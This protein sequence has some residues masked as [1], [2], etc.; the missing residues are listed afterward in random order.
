MFRLVPVARDAEQL[1]SPAHWHSSLSAERKGLDGNSTSYGESRYA[2]VIGTQ[3]LSALGGLE[4]SRDTTNII[5]TL[6]PAPRSTR[7]TSPGLVVIA[8]I[9]CS[10]SCR[11]R[12]QN[13][14][15]RWD[16]Y[17]EGQATPHLHLRKEHPNRLGGRNTQAIKYILRFLL[18]ARFHSS[19]D[20][21]FFHSSNVAHSG[22]GLR[23]MIIFS[24]RRRSP[25]PWS[26]RRK[27]IGWTAWFDRFLLGE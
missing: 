26:R 12:T 5:R 13:I 17:C 24:E 21:C 22:Y 3:R 10:L 19:S 23:A 18:E 20:N 2:D 25:I 16:L 6:P 4:S 1:V 11:R 8:C 14:R 7:Y 9:K 27:G 15:I